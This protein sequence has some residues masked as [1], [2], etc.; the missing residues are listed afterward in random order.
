MYLDNEKWA[1]A[2]AE[3]CPEINDLLDV[4]INA[5]NKIN[6]I[7]RAE[8]EEM[9]GWLKPGTIMVYMEYKF[10]TSSSSLPANVTPGGPDYQCG[11]Y[12]FYQCDLHH[13]MLMESRV[14]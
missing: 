5:G 12:H 10:L 14:S 4:E 3:L 1:Q 9:A 8:Q 11:V 13:H 7:Y 6:G 2:F